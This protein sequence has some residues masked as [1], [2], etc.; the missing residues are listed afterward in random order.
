MDEVVTVI[1]RENYSLVHVLEDIG[2]FASVIFVIFKLV[3]HFVNMNLYIS[4]LV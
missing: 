1:E 3:A 2:G 4:E